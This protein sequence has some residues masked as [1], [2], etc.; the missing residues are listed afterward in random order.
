[1]AEQ[2]KAIKGLEG[3]YEVSD[4][5][6]IRSYRCRRC[7]TGENG[8]WTVCYFPRLIGEDNPDTYRSNRY[9][10]TIR[11][12]GKTRSVNV[13]AEVLKAFVGPPGKGQMPYLL[14]G[15]PTN[16]RVSN[17]RWGTRSEI[18]KHYIDIGHRRHVRGE[19][20]WTAR[21]TENDVRE[22]RRLAESRPGPWNRGDLSDRAIAERY[23]VG[24]VTIRDIIE[25]RSWKHVE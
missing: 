15:D 18:N 16:L 17:L 5:G 7:G 13:A 24:R 20:V 9:R 3:V 2:W 11:V 4:R 22:I 8:G 6:R 10:T 1:M 23:G 12:N 14:D 25:R 21:L 19:H